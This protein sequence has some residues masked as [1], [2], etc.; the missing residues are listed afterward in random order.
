MTFIFR[1]MHVGR[2]IECRPE[3]FRMEYGIIFPSQI[4]LRERLDSNA[5]FMLVNAPLRLLS[6][7]TFPFVIY[8]GILFSRVTVRFFLVAFCFARP[9]SH[10]FPSLPRNGKAVDAK[11]R[12]RM[13]ARCRFGITSC[14]KCH[15]KPL[16]I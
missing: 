1:Y 14:R 16:R 13:R 2:K 15:D 5:S 12:K 6:A 4:F 7:H 11:E 3:E 9:H 8:L 10:F